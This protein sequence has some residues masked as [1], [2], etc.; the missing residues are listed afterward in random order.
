M[1]ACARIQHVL[2]SRHFRVGPLAATHEQ[3]IVAFQRN[4]IDYLEG[5]LP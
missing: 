5:A 2:W 3:P 1:E 4:V